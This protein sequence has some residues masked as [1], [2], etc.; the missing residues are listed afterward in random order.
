MALNSVRRA[1]I[2]APKTVIKFA[3]SKSTSA[4]DIDHQVA[5]SYS[6]LLYSAPDSLL[7]LFLSLPLAPSK[8]SNLKDLTLYLVEARVHQN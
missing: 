5:L 1:S 6:L 2:F 7:L 3:I 4:Y 8:L